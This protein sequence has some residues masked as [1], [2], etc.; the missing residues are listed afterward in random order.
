MTRSVTLYTC[1]RCGISLAEVLQAFADRTMFGL[2]YTPSWCGLTRLS[3][4]AVDA[5]PVRLDLAQ[6]FEARFFNQDLELRWLRKPEGQGEGRAVCLA[7]DSQTLPD[8]DRLEPVQGI[9]SLK[10]QY[11]LAGQGCP[12]DHLPPDWSAL[13]TAA[14]GTWSVP[15]ADL[16]NGARA[17][18]QYVEYLGPA[19]DVDGNWAVIDERLVGLAKYAEQ[20]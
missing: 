5:G 7:E 10:G 4:G 2:I 6:P 20:S 18:L 11:L 14:I 19:G 16:A 13:S 17:V 9:E 8:W 1:E 15:L 3:G 12:A